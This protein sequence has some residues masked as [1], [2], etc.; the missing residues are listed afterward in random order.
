MMCSN[1]LHHVFGVAK[2]EINTNSWALPIIVGTVIITCALNAI[3]V[4]L[5]VLIINIRCR[6]DKINEILPK[7]ATNFVKISSLLMTLTEICE[8]FNQIF[9]IP[10]MSSLGGLL[11]AATFYLY[12]FYALLTTENVRMEQIGYSINTNLWILYFTIIEFA[13]VACCSMTSASENETIEVLYEILRKNKCEK[14]RKR[15][16]IMIQQLKHAKIRFSCGLFE[17]DWKI[18]LSVRFLFDFG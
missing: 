16:K 2:E 3:L 1:V 13:F 9:A 17:F 10:M 6:I 11:F 18:A 14:E 7:N 15:L 4:F 8:L 5:S 12:D